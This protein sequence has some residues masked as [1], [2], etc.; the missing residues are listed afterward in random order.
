M[1]AWQ[2]TPFSLLYLA[3]FIVAT[4]VALTAWRLRPIRGAGH[5]SLMATS[6]AVWVIGY[7]LGV[8]NADLS[9]K[10]MA[11]R[12]EYIGIVGAPVMFFL[13]VAAYVQ[14]RLPRGW[15]AVIL[16]PAGV[17]YLSVLTFPM[18]GLLYETYGT[19][20][21]ENGFVV[22]V[23]DY[24]PVFYLWMA[25]SYV[26]MMGS[27]LTLAWGVGRM[28]VNYRFQAT[29]LGGIIAMVLMANL[30]FVSGINPIAP[31][32]PTPLAFLIASVLVLI[33][34]RIFRFLDI[35]PVAYNRVFDQVPTGVVVLN[36]RDQAVDMNRFAERVLGPKDE[37][38]GHDVSSWLDLN[39]KHLKSV[40]VGNRGREFDIEITP[41]TEAGG[42]RAGRLVL[43]HDVTRH[44]EMAAQQEA[45]IKE[46]RKALADVRVLEGMLPV[47]ANCKKIRDD[48]NEWHELDTFINRHSN[49]Q[50][51]HGICPS[52]SKL[53]YPGF[54]SD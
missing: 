21:L 47:C 51:S 40:E 52:C 5:F 26:M 15:Q 8:F 34:M 10:L 49:A 7:L 14:L 41:F 35:V 1:T 4:G 48:D 43:M 31:Y 44:N 46:L 33:N 17:T 28:P 25:F 54:Q 50:F 42:Q 39:E 13:F 18:H 16:I 2:F 30:A 29:V 11:L 53:L 12:I 36:D 24:G 38:L 37:I 6:V 22:F 32:D 27:F 19:A 45:L 23:K 3:G 9:W 20:T